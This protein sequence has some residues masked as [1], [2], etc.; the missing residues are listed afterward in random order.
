M[1]LFRY[2]LQGAGW[3]LGRSAAREGIDALRD[4]E[5]DETSES[6]PAPV[7]PREAR[8]RERELRIAAKKRAA[9]LEREL[10]ELKKRAG[11]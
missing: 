10:A 3:E 11:R 9:Q 7:D 1:G 5:H 4:G 6:A 8:R 2:I